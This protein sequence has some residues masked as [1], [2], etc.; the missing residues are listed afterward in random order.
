MTHP[1][2]GSIST[3]RPLT[4]MGILGRTHSTTLPD[5]LDR[6]LAWCAARGVEPLLGENALAVRPDGGRP[7][8]AGLDTVDVLVTLGGDGTLL[9]GAR[10]AGTSGTP[11]LGVNLGRLGFLASVPPEEMEVALDRFA[12]GEA[13]LDHRRTLEARVV[14]DGGVEDEP[15]PALNDLVIHGARAARVVHL[16]LSVEVAGVEDTIGSFSGDGVIVSTPTGST[17]YSLSSGGPIVA[18]AVDC[19]LVTAVSPHTMAV[20]PLLLPPDGIVRIGLLPRSGEVVVTADG[21]EVVS[22]D[23]T[24]QVMIRRSQGAVA[25]V[26]FSGDSFFATLRQKLNWAVESVPDPAHGSVFPD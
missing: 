3:A 11:V 9:R 21:R 14:R 5:V 2:D 15:F 8:R 16:T 22:L 13:R 20:R 26:R 10:A 17:A 7:Y 24:D 25:L 18:P 4:R 6:L 23:A 19:I 1:P 12:A